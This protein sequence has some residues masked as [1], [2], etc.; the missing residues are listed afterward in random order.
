MEERE[1]APSAEVVPDSSAATPVKDEE[2][3]QNI[4]ADAS[5]LAKRGVCEAGIEITIEN[6]E[7]SGTKKRK[8]EGTCDV[9]KNTEARYCCPR[10]NTRSCS[11]GCCKKH[12]IDTKCS[13]ERQKTAFIPITEFTD[14]NLISGNLL[15]C[16]ISA[17]YSLDLHFLEDGLRTAES[18]HKSLPKSRRRPTKKVWHDMIAFLH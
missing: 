16:E 13:G 15:Q 18:A 4:L 6:G 12:K 17:N 1:T 3:E 14:S 7:S 2:W 5:N 10:C 11:L 9:C 8:I